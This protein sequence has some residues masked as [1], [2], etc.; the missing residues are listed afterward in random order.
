MAEMSAVEHPS[1]AAG[2]SGVVAAFDFALLHRADGLFTHRYCMK[3][4]SLCSGQPHSRQA[5]RIF[6]RAPNA[7]LDG[8]I[9]ELR[10]LGL[11]TKVIGSDDNP[12]FAITDTGRR[13]VAIL[14]T[15]SQDLQEL[16]PDAPRRP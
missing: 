1:P 5:L 10:R 7:G 3:V 8:A 4:L 13:A 11:I 6:G 9:K 12:V 15:L 2:S 14:N 16:W